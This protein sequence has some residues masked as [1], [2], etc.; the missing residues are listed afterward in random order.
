MYPLQRP[1]GLMPP[2]TRDCAACV[3]GGGN[4]APCLRCALGLGLDLAQCPIHAMPCL[5]CSWSHWRRRCSALQRDRCRAL[6]TA[7]RLALPCESRK[8]GGGHLLCRVFGGHDVGE[9]GIELHLLQA[10]VLLERRLPQRRELALGFLLQDAASRHAPFR[11]RLT[12][13]A[14]LLGQ[15]R[16]SPSPAFRSL[17]DVC[18]EP[19][20]PSR[21]S[22]R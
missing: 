15:R 9:G 22:R 2:A 10:G 14:R 6:G 3:T 21:G 17:A 5:R 1:A 18:A 4:P 13:L 19:C 11:L 7:T 16:G 8:V 20:A 12:L